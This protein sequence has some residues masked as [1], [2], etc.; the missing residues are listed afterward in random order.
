MMGLAI[1][2]DSANIKKSREIKGVRSV[3]IK[4]KTDACRFA[5][6]GEV[7]KWICI[8]AMFDIIQNVSDHCTLDL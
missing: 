4:K 6:I 1:G 8:F 7:K 5:V 3:R 2:R